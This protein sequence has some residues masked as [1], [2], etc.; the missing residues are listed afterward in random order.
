MNAR[1]QKWGNSLA[2]RIPKPFAKQI[3][4]S[5]NSE[6]DLSVDQ[7]CLVLA[8]QK[9]PKYKLSDLLRTIKKSQLHGEVKFGPPRGREIL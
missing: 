5:S 8:P 7:G 2:I 4:L 6:V 1:V 3:G 9:R